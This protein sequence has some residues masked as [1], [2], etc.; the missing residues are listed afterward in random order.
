MPRALPMV[1][2]AAPLVPPR[3][4]LTKLK[5]AAACCTACDLYKRATQTVFGEG[6]RAADAMFV[7][8]VPGNDE[9]LAGKPFV[10][11]AGRLLDQALLEVGLDRKRIYLTNAVKHF[12]WRPAGT[13]RLHEKPNAREMAACRPWLQAELAV[14]KPRILVCL[15]A[16]A[17]QA[18]LGPRFRVTKQRGEVLASELAPAVLAT[19]HPASILRAPDEDARR[20]E[21]RLFLN[22]LSKVAEMLRQ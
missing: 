6:P 13:R 9:D 17:A 4:T 11:P 16:T 19:V 1:Q 10:G 3:P 7:G 8:E 18:V 20:R 12:K 22:D 5:L 15:G 21:L 2:T 14:V